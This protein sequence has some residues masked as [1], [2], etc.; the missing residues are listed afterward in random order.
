MRLA[1]K[2]L[3]GDNRLNILY[4]E[5]RNLVKM[6]SRLGNGKFCNN[7]SLSSPEIKVSYLF[8]YRAGSPEGRYQ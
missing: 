2:S 1:G 8:T 3:V 7:E 5:K 4:L 6:Y